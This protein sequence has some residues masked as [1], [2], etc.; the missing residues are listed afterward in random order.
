MWSEIIFDL[1][2]EA[3]LGGTGHIWSKREN[4]RRKGLGFRKTGVLIVIVMC[5]WNIHVSASGDGG[6]ASLAGMEKGFVA[7]EGF[8]NLRNLLRKRKQP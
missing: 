3:Q 1:N 5:H 2:F 7:S 6:Y 8:Y 4:E